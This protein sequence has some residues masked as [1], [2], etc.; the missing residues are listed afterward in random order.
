MTSIAL[1]SA[2]S[3]STVFGEQLRSVFLALRKESLA[4]AGTLVVLAALAAY[5]ALRAGNDPREGMHLSYSVVATVPIALVALLIPFSVWRTEDPSRRAYHWAMP[6]ARAPHTLIK[7]VCGWIW[8]M[9]AVVVY[10]LWIVLVGLMIQ[11][12]RGS[13]GTV[14]W[15]P[16][17]TWLVPF[18]ATTVTY[19]ITSI[20]AI[21][22][23]HPWRWIAGVTLGYFVLIAFLGVLQMHDA[24]RALGTITSGYYGL[25]AAAFG[26]VQHF[27]GPSVER[28]IEATLVWGAL[29]VIGVGLAAARR[30]E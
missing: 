1:H 29:S 11:A 3:R 20:A 15:A 18:T 24:E 28:W 4:F 16:A 9:C 25:T 17:W 13:M 14:H 2:P 10:L 8:V 22:S 12:I 7:L 27:G 26:A 21:A 5:A 30:P 6:V 23:D 19:L